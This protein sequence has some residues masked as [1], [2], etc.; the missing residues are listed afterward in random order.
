[1]NESRSRYSR[2]DILR[3][4]LALGAVTLASGAPVRYASALGSPLAAT[5]VI[6]PAALLSSGGVLFGG[7]QPGSPGA[8]WALDAFEA[9]LGQRPGI[10]H[11]YQ[12]WGAGNKSLDLSLLDAAVGR[13]A[14]PMITWEPW[15]YT[16]GIDQPEF[17]LKRIRQGAFDAYIKSWAIGLRTYGRPVLLRF[18]H[19]MNGDWYPWSVKA[20]GN[21]AADFVGAW[22]RVVTIFRRARADNVA[23]VWCPNALGDWSAPLASCFPGDSYVDV[24]GIDGYNAGTSV[25]W[26]GWRS[27]EDLF[28]ATYDAIAA[29]ST[30]PFII[31]ETGCSEAGGDKS[32]WVNDMFAG[33]ERRF[34]RVGGISWFNEA[35]EAD[36]RIESSAASLAVFRAALT[37]T[38][39]GIKSAPL[40]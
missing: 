9:T 24:V 16:K 21:T 17:S 2:R 35:R 3:A 18:A 34:P 13:G 1:M 33:R 7:W 37:N 23:F 39:Y 8:A 14:L 15:D 31:G 40:A 5:S 26:G 6:G 29:M 30:R 22:R 32:V 28:G 4:S 20:N 27:F 25:N 10:V 19:E 36:W 38:A 11:W 12:G